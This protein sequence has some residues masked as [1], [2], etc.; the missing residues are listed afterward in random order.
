MPLSI[1]EGDIQHYLKLLVDNFNELAKRKHIDYSLI[2]EGSIYGYYDKE[3]LERILFN[4]LSNA[5]KFTP[6]E[7]EIT[8]TIEKIDDRYFS[9]EIMDTDQIFTT[10]QNWIST[11][12]DFL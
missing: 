8:V 5:F 10:I 7:G 11:I 12:F 6:N 4:L 3:I 2:S 1:A 9:L